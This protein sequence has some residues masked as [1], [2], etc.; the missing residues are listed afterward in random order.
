MTHQ[1]TKRPRGLGWIVAIVTIEALVQIVIFGATFVVALVL[2]TGVA[3]FDAFNLN[4]L[5]EARARAVVRGRDLLEVGALMALAIFALI[6]AIG[7]QRMRPWGWLMVL[8]VQGIEL[9]IGIY[10]YAQSGNPPLE[11]AIGALVV[12]YLNARNVRVALLPSSSSVEPKSLNPSAA[13]P[14]T[15]EGIDRIGEEEFDDEY[16]DR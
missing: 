1:P 11:L 10:R 7:L 9:A 12:F 2:Y 16:V 5:A 14:G 15:E 6:G 3:P 4:A 8:I 13:A